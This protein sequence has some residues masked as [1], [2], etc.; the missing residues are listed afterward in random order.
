MSS[1]TE[2]QES[3][4]TDLICIQQHDTQRPPHVSKGREENLQQQ[5]RRCVNSSYTLRL[6]KQFSVKLLSCSHFITVH[7]KYEKSEAVT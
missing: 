2:I 6:S 4:P 1:E 7:H 3:T 5:F